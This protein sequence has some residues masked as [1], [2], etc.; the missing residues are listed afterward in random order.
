MTKQKVSLL[1]T[2]GE[3][4]TAKRGLLRLLD[5]EHEDGTRATIQD[6]INRIEA[7]ERFFDTKKDHR[8]RI[9]S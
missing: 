9:E 3:A 4:K 7:M 5:D 2:E 8:G 1:I 6:L